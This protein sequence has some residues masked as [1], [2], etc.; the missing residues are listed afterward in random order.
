[1]AR[2]DRHYLFSI[3]RV[4]ELEKSL[5][6]STHF[7]RVL[8]ASDPLAVLRSVGFFETAEDHEHLESVQLIFR[9]ER[10]FNRRQLHELIADS[11]V[12]D[13]FRL[14]CDVETLKRLLKGKLTGAMS[15]AQAKEI[16]VEEGK[17]RLADLTAVVYDGAQIGL[18]AR[19]A[20]AAKWTNELFQE[21]PEHALI[22][23]RLDRALRAE[24]IDIARQD[25]S[26]FL[27]NYFQRLSD[28]Q[29]LAVVMRRKWH[30]FGHIPLKDA[31]FETGTLT[32]SWFEGVYDCGWESLATAFKPTDYGKIVA[33][34]VAD[35]END[36]FLPLFDAAC[37]N[38]LIELLHS[39]KYLSSGLE[40]VVA[41]YLA[42]DHELKL[43]RM[44]LAGKVFGFAQDAL[45]QRVKRLY[46]D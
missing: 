43:V 31:L 42:R 28:V 17:F 5:L 12:E 21:R 29:N 18:P 35:V 34:A 6:N 44:I 30:R 25:G 9:R 40:P 24:Q 8:E 16:T 36:A 37:A 4:R 32:A 38:Y 41:L 23:S 27:T 46:I 11:P 7:D 45:R 2:V 3:G 39:A 33:D 10:E 19:I 22:D 1:M 13:M 14:S 20:N 26:R 15:A